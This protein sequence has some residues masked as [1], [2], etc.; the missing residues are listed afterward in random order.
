MKVFTLVIIFTATSLSLLW[1]QS[2]GGVSTGLNMWLKSDAG[3]SKQL[4][5]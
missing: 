1:S 3:N 5:H 4:I 2:P